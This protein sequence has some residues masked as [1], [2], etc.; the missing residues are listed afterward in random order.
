MVFCVPLIKI[1]GFSK[2]PG[3]YF[4]A[5]LRLGYLFCYWQIIEN[6]DSNLVLIT[7]FAFTLET[8]S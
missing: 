4:K 7:I 6:K 3:L 1:Q 2:A 8:L 5:S